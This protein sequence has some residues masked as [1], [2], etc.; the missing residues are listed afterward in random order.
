MSIHDDPAFERTRKAVFDAIEPEAGDDS[1]AIISGAP[2]SVVF[3][4]AAICPPDQRDAMR[5]DLQAKLADHFDQ[6]ADLFDAS[7]K[8]PWLLNEPRHP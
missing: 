2:H 1:E 7:G 4:A 5:A 3:F 6:V 8:T